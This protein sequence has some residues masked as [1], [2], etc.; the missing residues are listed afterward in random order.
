MADFIKQSLL[1]PVIQSVHIIGLT[2]LVGTICLMDLR[3]LGF[4]VR[5]QTPGNL[6]LRLAPWTTGGPAYLSDYPGGTQTN[7]FPNF[8]G[9]SV[10]L[11]PAVVF[12]SVAQA[13]GFPA[14]YAVLH[15]Y[16]ADNCL[17]K[18]PLLTPPGDPA[19][20]ALLQQRL[21]AYRAGKPWRQ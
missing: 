8:F 19:V 12:P 5:Q 17:A 2:I 6:A 4:G 16:G 1:F 20:A 9:G 13:V 14:S 15:K 3:L 21:D 18:S 11:P 10:P 7:T